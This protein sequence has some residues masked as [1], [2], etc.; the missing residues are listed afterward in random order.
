MQEVIDAKNVL[1]VFKTM[2]INLEEPPKNEESKDDDGKASDDNAGKESG[3]GGDEEPKKADIEATKEEAPKTEEAPKEET[4]EDSK[5]DD[6]DKNKEAGDGDAEKKDGNDAQPNDEEKK[7]EEEATDPKNPKYEGK[8]KVLID[9]IETKIDDLQAVIMGYFELSDDLL[10]PKPDPETKEETKAT[11]EAGAVELTQDQ[12]DEA[13]LAKLVT[14]LQP[15]MQQQIQQMQQLLQMQQMAMMAML[16]RTT[17]T[18]V[19]TTTGA[20]IAASPM[21]TGGTLPLFNA[22]SSFLGA[23]PLGSGQQASGL[24]QSA[25]EEAKAEV[26][27][28]A[29]EPE[30]KDRTKECQ[31]WFESSKLIEDDEYET[32]LGFFNNDGDGIKSMELLY[33]GSENDF[34]AEQFHEKCDDQGATLFLCQS[35]HTHIF[36]GFTKESWKDTSSNRKGA[37]KEDTD[38]FIFILRSPKDDVLP[39]SWKV[40]NDKKDKTIKADAR[41]GP[42][43]GYGYDIRICDQCH[44]TKESSSQ[45]DNDDACFGVP[46]DD[47]YLTGE[48]YFLVSEYE[49]YKVNM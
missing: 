18:G 11:E 25:T 29:K 27:E 43:F 4:K 8:Y 12:K 1:N 37:W 36:G 49:V 2:L 40:R 9:E 32:L 21:A 19:T 16:A 34:S 23:P 14:K 39:G 5:P 24:Q 38:A 28:E 30:K 7:T 45:I 46:G 22:Q 20:V 42:Q 31:G 41:F 44:E 15:N 33:R 26:K 13:L 35:E 17:T 3:G 10:P 48:F 47:D 6:G